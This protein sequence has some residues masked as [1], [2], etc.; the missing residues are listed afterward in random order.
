LLD[1]GDRFQMKNIHQPVNTLL[2]VMHVMLAIDYNR[3]LAVP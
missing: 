1:T 2:V 3:H